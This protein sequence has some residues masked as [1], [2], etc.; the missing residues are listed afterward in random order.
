[1]RSSAIAEELITRGEDAIFVGMT[2][3]LPWVAERI[4]SLGFSQNYCDS[5]DFNSRPDSD[6]LILDAYE[7]DQSESFI[8]PRNW[9]SIVAIVD[10]LT[11][12]YKCTLRIH[13]GLDSDWTGN[14][15]TPILAGPRFIPIRSS[16]ARKTQVNQEE[17]RLRIVVVAGGSDPYK[18][19][20]EIARILTKATEDFEVYLFTSFDFNSVA[21]SRFHYVQLGQQL[22]DITQDADLVIT[23]ASTSSL[24]FLARG[25]CVGMVC[26]VDNQRQYYNSLGRLGVAAQLG[27]RA[28]DSH[29]EI[30]PHEI[31]SLI[32]SNELRV[33]LVS[34]AEGLI[35]FKGAS[36]IV[37]AITTL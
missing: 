37:D 24:E 30:D 8:N 33:N 15:K 7:I 12:E 19:V 36:R 21:D 27:F 18:L 16:L 29:W 9:H 2:S 17:H 28:V 10:E 3:E 4:A 25:L 11:P 31:Y 14:S 20:H 1:M 13:P 26:A 32:T 23:T 35:D 6:V 5:K 22:D 34:R